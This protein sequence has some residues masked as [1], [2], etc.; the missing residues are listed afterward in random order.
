MKINFL[1]AFFIV[2]CIVS[3]FA[4]DEIVIEAALEVQ[5]NAEEAPPNADEAPAS[6]EES[7]SPSDETSPAIADPAVEEVAE[8][9][10]LEEIFA[11]N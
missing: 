10:I 3:G 2:G 4:Q 7:P 6:P 1:F 8:E 9:P 11:E 5:P